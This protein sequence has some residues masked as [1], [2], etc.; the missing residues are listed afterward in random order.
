MGGMMKTASLGLALGTWLLLA[1]LAYAEAPRFVG[2]GGGPL[3]PSVEVLPGEALT[4]G[5]AGGT[6]ISVVSIAPSSVGTEVE[7][8]DLQ[9][10]FFRFV[11]PATGSFAGTWQVTAVDEEEVEVGLTLVVRPEMVAERRAIG[12]LAPATLVEVL[13]LVP[14]ATPEITLRSDDPRVDALV[15]DVAPASDDEPVGNPAQVW[16]SVD[17][18]EDWQD[19]FDLT[20]EV[21]AGL[22]GEAEDGGWE[23]APSVTLRGRIFGPGSTALPGARIRTQLARTAQDEPWEANSDAEGRFVLQIGGPLLEGERLQVVAPGYLTRSSAADFCTGLSGCQVVLTVSDIFLEG[24]VEGL[25][26]GESVRLSLFA[27]EPAFP[28]P[29]GFAD[30]EAT[31]DAVVAWSI[32]AP[33]RRI[34]PRL[35]VDGVGYL[36]QVLEGPEDAGWDLTDDDLEPV[37]IVVEPTAPSVSDLTASEADTPEVIRWQ[38]VLRPEERA[39]VWSV[40]LEE[41]GLEIFRSPSTEYV[42]DEAEIVLEEVVDSGRCGTEL[43]L[44]I[45]AENNAGL[46]AEESVSVEMAGCVNEPDDVG[47]DPDRDVREPDAGGEDVSTPAPDAD[48]SEDVDS[49]DDARGDVT[50]GGQGSDGCGCAVSMTGANGVPGAVFLLLLLGLRRVR[51]RGVRAP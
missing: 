17:G 8:Q 43:V 37:T 47:S 3:G 1:S 10:G 31:D 44:R 46:Q 38:V 39:G 33:E 36:S 19:G 45:L 41:D 30:V 14:G 49:S 18:G 7:L 51:R 26:D 15:V 25:L 16:L 6:G 2:V 32:P 11:A 22:S 13:G 48:G 21:D 40:V 29:V 9:D 35:E 27:E 4:L 5:V 12:V 23:V 42:G 50:P 34:Y 28:D 20:V 24:T